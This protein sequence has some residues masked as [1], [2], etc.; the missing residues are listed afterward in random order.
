MVRKSSI[1][2]IGFVILILI[3]AVVL[4]VV[5]GIDGAIAPLFVEF[6]GICTTMIVGMQLVS[7]V[8]LLSMQKRQQQLVEEQAELKQQLKEV[9]RQKERLECMVYQAEGFGLLEQN[10]FFAFKAIL[11]AFEKAYSIRSVDLSNQI[12]HNL[13][14]I[15]NMVVK[16]LNQ[17]DGKKGKSYEWLKE[18]IHQYKFDDAYLNHQLSYDVN[19][20]I[21]EVS[22]KMTQNNK[23]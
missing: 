16:K 23:L 1:C 19:R 11:K 3:I 17:K 12:L 6:I 18:H 20:I 9:K 5:N 14:I 22:D 13:E 21:K 15:K 8:T 2:C 7:V 4:R 10:P